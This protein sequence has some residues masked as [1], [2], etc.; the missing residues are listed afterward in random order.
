MRVVCASS[1]TDSAFVGD[2]ILQ[3]RSSVTNIH[4]IREW[5]ILVTAVN[6][7]VRMHF[8]CRCIMI[9]RKRRIDAH[10]FNI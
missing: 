1:Q 5:E 7:D 4:A 9:Y 6:G 2:E 10:V 8:V 3:A